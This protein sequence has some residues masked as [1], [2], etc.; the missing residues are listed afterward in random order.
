MPKKL[1]IFSIIIYVILVSLFCFWKYFNYGYNGLD[2]AIFN[3]VF[4]NSVQGDLFQFTIHPQSYLGDHFGIIILF[5][6]PF[7]CLFLSPLTL[8]FLQTI[9][10]ALSAWPLF[11]IAKKVL[12]EKIALFISLLWLLNPFILNINLFEF[13]LLPFALFFIFFTFYYYQQKKFIPFLI[14]LLISLLIREDVALVMLMFGLLALIEKRSLKW[15]LSPLIVSGVWF[16]ITL[17]LIAYFTPAGQYKF[18]YYYAWLGSDFNEIIK[19]LFFNPYLIVRHLFSW[20]N[21]FF[22]LGLFIPFAFL[23]I[24]QPKYL[25]LALLLF[26]QILL[27]GGNNTIIVLFIH[28]V[29]LFLPIMFIALIYEIKKIRNGN[30]LNIIEKFIHKE[31][32]ALY[33]ILGLT[34]VYTFFTLGP[35]LG[36]FEKN[37]STRETANKDLFLSQISPTDSV[38]T[39]FEFLP[40]LSNRKKL[41]SLHYAYI[42]KLQFS[43]IDYL[44]PKDT[45][46]ILVD[47][48][49]FLSYQLL[50]P[51][52]S[53][54]QDYY[55]ESD[56]RFRN[57]L[58]NNN[59]QA[60]S[61]RD[62]VVLF[63]KNPEK[64]IELYTINPGSLAS[65]PK[66][67]IFNNKIIFLGWDKDY[68]DNELLSLSLYFKSLQNLDKHYN[69]K[70]KILDQD[71]NPV[72]QKNYT[73][74]YGLLPTT[75]WEI[76]EVI[77]INYNFLLPDN[78]N[79]YNKKISFE[80]F[81][82]QGGLT[83][84]KIK[85]TIPGV[86]E[87]NI[88]GQFFISL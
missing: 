34:A 79:I 74:A 87:E 70:L 72:H 13:H 36:L 14:F 15:V 3:Q 51:N 11:L 80:L 30:Q 10:I 6:L 41:Y 28:Y 32:A 27:S 78:I 84:N 25:L 4:F 83:L 66:N 19:N 5:L 59:Y 57:F 53:V 85:Y 62:S 43:K 58:E 18:L 63:E 55:E 16:I 81:E 46:K 37:F 88:L 17:K 38:A 33:L 76:D 26:A 47:S 50:F 77:K 21:I 20:Q 22:L 39:T 69:L 7:Y 64:T 52:I 73:M 61:V 56:N 86:A 67:E 31:R 12:N 48:Q 29:T 65:N 71:D 42:G 2:L 60:S 1:L 35:F 75:D 40:R 23:N 45:D 24:F 49:D 82:Q 68:I 8:L 9:F 44:L 54:W